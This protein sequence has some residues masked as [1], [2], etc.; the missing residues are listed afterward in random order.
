[1]PEVDSKDVKTLL[2]YKLTPLQDA[3]VNYLVPSVGSCLLFAFTLAA[4][5]A[6][7]HR[8]F[9][10]E[11]PTWAHLILW[12]MYLPVAGSLVLIVTDWDL[13]PRD[14]EIKNRMTRCLWL[15]G[16]VLEHVFFPVWMMWRY[17]ER[18]FWSIEAIVASDEVKRKEAKTYV[19]AP[20]NIELYVFL[21]AYLY[22]LPQ[23]ML[24]LYILMRHEKVVEKETCKSD[25]VN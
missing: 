15:F 9:K 11:H 18:I 2:T 23:V 13:W 5:I 12:L 8:H 25:S 16:K 21:Q 20:R 3:I 4:D 24:Q 1:M 17:A 6:L 14:E 22:A 7:I 10:D 19:Y